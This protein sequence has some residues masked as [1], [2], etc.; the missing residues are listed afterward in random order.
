MDHFITVH[1]TLNQ[2]FKYKLPVSAAFVCHPLS[3]CQP[4]WVCQSDPLSFCLVLLSMSAPLVCLPMSVCLYDTA[5]QLVSAIMASCHIILG[6]SYWVPLHLSNGCCHQQLPSG[7]LDHF[8]DLS[9][10]NSHCST[11]SWGQP[12]H[13][14][15]MFLKI[16]LLQSVKNM[17]ATMYHEEIGSYFSGNKQTEGA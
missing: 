1:H 17:I 4:M 9:L 11:F 14:M 3:N 8:H 7:N 2:S 5:C 6:L 10:N 13:V 16:V 12:W 15:V